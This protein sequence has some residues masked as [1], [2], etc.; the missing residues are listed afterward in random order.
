MLDTETYPA[1]FNEQAVRSLTRDGYP[2]T[3][4]IQLAFDQGRSSSENAPFYKQIQNNSRDSLRGRFNQL[5]EEARKAVKLV[6]K[7]RDQLDGM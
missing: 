6:K 3:A 5:V 1:A 7:A 4:L 2:W